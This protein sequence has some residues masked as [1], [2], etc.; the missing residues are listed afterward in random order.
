MSEDQHTDSQK[1]IHIR[2]I[3][4]ATDA[5]TLLAAKGWFRLADVFKILAPEDSSR[6]K[7]A[8]KQ[9]ERLVNRGQDPFH[10]LGYR[11]EGG[12]I[13]IL[14]ERFAPWYQ[15]NPMFHIQKVHPNLLF[16]NFLELEE[17]YFRLSEI[18][19]HFGDFMPYSYPTL[20]RETDKNPSS[21][22]EIGIMKFDKNYIVVMPQFARLL[23]NSF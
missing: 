7:L 20:K 4:A 6:Y 16:E 8:F 9:V 3:T 22:E 19:N 23:R 1:K 17:G 2:R 11:K 15:S 18:C 12:R 13:T 14:M 5:E 21:K 10:I